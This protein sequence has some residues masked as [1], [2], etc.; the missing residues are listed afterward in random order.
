MKSLPFIIVLLFLFFH[1]CAPVAVDK[2]LERT[3]L[4]FPCAAGDVTTDEAVLWLRAERESS[5]S[6]HYGREP[7][8]RMFS[9]TRPIKVTEQT[10]FTAKVMINGLEPKTTYYY[11]GAVVGRKPGPICKFVTAPQAD[12]PAAVQFAFSGDTRESYQPFSIMD[13]IRAM[14]PDFFIHLGD[15]IYADRGGVASQLPDFWAKYRGNRNDL[16][17]QRLFSETS[18][19]VTWDDHEVSGNYDPGDPLAPIGQRAFFDYWP[20]R[21]DPKDPERLY[22]SFRWGKAVELFILDTR[23]YRDISAGTILG[24]EQKKWFL[25][26]L[27]SSSAWFKFVA[28]SVPI[29]SRGIDKWGGYP[30]DREEVLSHIRRER[31]RG[32]IFLTADVHFAAVSKVPG[33][34]GLKEFIVGP[35]ATQVNP[36]IR[37]AKRFEFF[38]ND[39][40]SYGLVKVH[41]GANPPYTE[42]SI[43]DEN[44]KLLHK[45]RIDILQ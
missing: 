34:S 3:G 26:A 2:R 41:A 14:R 9:A 35:L 37:T 13:S 42:I 39:S 6:V 28:T 16:P 7:D 29:S 31:I 8:L 43:L 21:Q 32:V 12:D 44:N 19:Y 11:R 24:R 5:L 18:L 30:V 45:T 36:W 15:T 25:K 1:G 17:T 38:S 40:F 27:S 23:Q 22:R 10:D 4:S 20:I 33:G